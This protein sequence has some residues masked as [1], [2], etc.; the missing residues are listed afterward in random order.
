[1]TAV[2]WITAGALG[3]TTTGLVHS[4]VAHRNSD[5]R[6]AYV[7]VARA[8]RRWMFPAAFGL[9]VCVAV[10]GAILMQVPVLQFS[11]WRLISGAT[12]SMVTGQTGFHGGLWTAAA[13]FHAIYNALAVLLLLTF[14]IARVVVS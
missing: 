10:A 4:V 6:T 12:G 14:V 11:W 13:A 3:L 5:I 1:M 9:L 2:T 8:V 7:S